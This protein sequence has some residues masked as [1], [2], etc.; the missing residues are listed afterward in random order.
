MCGITGFIDFS[1]KQNQLTL[2]K[3][4]AT[5]KHRGPDDVGAILY[6]NEYAYDR[7]YVGI[8]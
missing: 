6:E 3:M 7:S 4:A 2:E 8:L 5:L 1:K